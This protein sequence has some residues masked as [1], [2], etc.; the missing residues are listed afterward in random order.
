MRFL[1]KKLQK[2]QNLNI[3]EDVEESFRV[4]FNEHVV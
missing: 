2:A 1:K 3:I 4:P